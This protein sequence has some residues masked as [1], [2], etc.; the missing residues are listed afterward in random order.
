MA[1]IQWE[2]AQTIWCDRLQQDAYLLEQR[3]YPEDP[4]PDAG[5]PYQIKARMC[6]CGEQCNMIGYSCRWAFTNPHL[7]PFAEV[8]G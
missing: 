7:D 4:I 8:G 1:R 5:R 2:I 6:S 3:I